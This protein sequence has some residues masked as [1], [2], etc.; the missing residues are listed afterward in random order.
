MI[1]DRNYIRTQAL[2][3]DSPGLRPVSHHS[4]FEMVKI[5][6]L[7]KRRAGLSFD[8][9]ISYYETRHAPLALS[10]MT[11]AIRYC[12]RYLRPLEQCPEDPHKGR[13]VEP[14]FD[15]ITELWVED[16][17]AA[18]RTLAAMAQPDVAAQIAVDEERLFDR[19]KTLLFMV[20]ERES[21]CRHLRR[22]L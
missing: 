7:L 11:S 18:R 5:V 10:H 1:Y 2:E 3:A 20:D 12:R 19:S 16:Q 4:V 13:W 17:E 22:T 9:F 14:P 21:N 6:A 8:D 15:A